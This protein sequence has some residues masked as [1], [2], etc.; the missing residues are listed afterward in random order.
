MKKKNACLI[1]YLY[2]WKKTNPLS[3]FIKKIKQKANKGRDKA[4]RKE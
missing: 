2:Y 3:G 1:A 4:K